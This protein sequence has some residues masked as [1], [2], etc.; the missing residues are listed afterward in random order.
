MPLTAAVQS[1]VISQAAAEFKEQGYTVIRGYLAGEDLERL[2]NE[3]ERY[4]NDVAPDLSGK[5]VYF[6][7]KKDPQSVFRMSLMH[8]YDS[9][10][11]EFGPSKPIQELADMMLGEEAS[12]QFIG[13]FGK[14][15]RIGEETPVH[16]DGHY[17]ML[18][19]NH[20]LT[21]WLALDRSDLENGCIRYV[22]GSHQRGMRPHGRLETFGFSQGITDM[23]PEDFAQEVAVE[24]DPGDL[25]VHH[26]LTIHRADPNPTDRRRWAIG[27]GYYAA[28]AV[29]DL[30]ARQK[31]HESLHSD[32]KKEGKFT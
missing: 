5:E 10:F 23:G 14:A 26:S 3:T 16:Q 1:S 7:D 15:P 12:F 30:E 20:A 29:P 19:P 4:L 22:P 27:M 28:S 11:A 32:W 25:I 2:Q 18:E 9:F 21:M 6:A 31:Y 8:Q 13:M 17:F 24:A